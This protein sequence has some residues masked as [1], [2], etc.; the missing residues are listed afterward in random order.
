M[1]WIVRISD[2]THPL[3]WFK[4]IKEYYVQV[5]DVI[6]LKKGVPCFTYYLWFITRLGIIGYGY[7]KF[8]IYVKSV[9]TCEV[10]IINTMVDEPLQITLLKSSFHNVCYKTEIM[11]KTEYVKSLTFKKFLLRNQKKT[12]SDRCHTKTYT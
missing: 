12:R 8:Y 3:Y 10:I 5:F 9:F 11:D 4:K 2:E 1:W 7:V 6:N